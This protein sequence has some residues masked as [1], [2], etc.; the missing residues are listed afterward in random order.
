MQKTMGTPTE[1]IRVHD[2]ARLIG[3]TVHTVYR[4]TKQGLLRPVWRGR[5]KFYE[6]ADVAAFAKIYNSKVD[7]S[8]VASLAMRAFIKADAAERKLAE[9][10]D[11][12]GIGFFQLSTDDTD[13]RDFYTDALRRVT[14]PPTLQAADAMLFAKKCLGI[15]EEYLQLVARLTDEG[16]EPWRPFLDALHYLCINAPRQHFTQDMELAA[17]YGYLEAARRHMRSLSYFYVHR[18]CGR[19][20][21]ATAF[22]GERDY[23]EPI[24]RALF[25]T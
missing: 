13:V 24:V 14:Y 7:W 22:N 19:S 4:L 9:L 17:A 25:P 8:N 1:Y 3:V 2:A 12:L 11:L 20:I 18:V 5:R 10:S 16:D 23:A 21:A 6:Q 15:T